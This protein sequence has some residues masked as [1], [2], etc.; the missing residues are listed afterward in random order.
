MRIKDKVLELFKSVSSGKMHCRECGY[1]ASMS[2][3]LD[4]SK[5][6]DLSMGRPECPNCG[7]KKISGG[8]L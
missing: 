6:T 4:D 1:Q 8:I 7:S 5:G 2:E 3:A